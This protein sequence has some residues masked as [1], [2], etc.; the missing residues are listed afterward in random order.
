MTSLE[1]ASA[2]RGMEE[3]EHED[4]LRDRG[5]RAFPDPRLT[6]RGREMLAR[7]ELEQAVVCARMDAYGPAYRKARA[8]GQ[9]EH[10]AHRT[11][12]AAE[13]AAESDVR[14]SA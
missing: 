13:E 12:L 5:G 8:V 1:T 4:W 11:A 2:L 14:R 7:V 10:T 9:D 3:D 6:F